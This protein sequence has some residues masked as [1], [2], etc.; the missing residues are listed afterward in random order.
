MP[1]NDS[2]EKARVRLEELLRGV[3]RRPEV[4]GGLAEELER[5]FSALRN[6]AYFVRQQRKELGELSREM[7]QL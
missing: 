5:V 3:C 7:D 2:L 6:Y 4:A 1:V